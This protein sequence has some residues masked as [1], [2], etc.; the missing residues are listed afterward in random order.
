MRKFTLFTILAFV[1]LATSQE[2][3]FAEGGIAWDPRGVPVCIASGNQQNIRMVPDGSGGAIIVWTDLRNDD[4]DI[5]AQKINQNGDRVWV[6]SD[7]AVCTATLG[8]KNP[9]IVGDGSGGAIIAWE[10]Y[11]GG[12]GNSNIY[13]VR[14]SS[15]GETCSPWPQDGVALKSI[16]TANQITPD[17][18]SV[19]S[20]GAVIVWQER[21][22]D[23]WEI[24]AQRRDMNGM[25]KWTFPVSSSA[26]NV[27]ANPK[28]INDGQG[29][30]I[31]TWEEIRYGINN[32]YAQ[33]LSIYDGIKHFDWDANGNVVTMAIGD[34]KKPGI[35]PDG[36][37]GAIIVWTDWRPPTDGTAP[38]DIYAQRISSGGVCM[39]S[40]D[41]DYNGIPICKMRNEQMN[42]VI[43][44]D[45]VG[46]ATIGAIIAWED[47]R[48]DYY[49]DIYAE[50]VPLN[51]TGWTGD[52]KA[53]A[54]GINIQQIL[55]RMVS[56]NQG[57]G[58]ITWI[59]NDLIS[60]QYKIFASKRNQDGDP[61]WSMYP[62]VLVCQS[63]NI[64]D[65]Q[66]VSDGSLGVII[67]WQSGPSSD[68]NI[69][70]QRVVEDGA[71]LFSASISGRV[72]LPDRETGITGVDVW[73]LKDE[74]LVSSVITGTN[75]DYGLTGLTP[76]T[77]YVVRANWMV[78]DIEFSVS[79]EAFAPSYSI[80]FTLEKDYLL[81]AIAGNVIGVEREAKRISGSGFKNSP[82]PGNGAA[83]VELEQRGKVIVKV[84]LEMDGGYII[85]N[86]L[87]G[88]F[89]AR[90]YN[91]S[92]YSAPRVVNL[93]EGET[94]RV[95]FAFGIIPEESVFNYPNPAKNGSTTIRYYCGYAEPEAEIRIYDIAGE[96]VR[97]V[98]DG[99][100]DKTRASE[101]I[102]SF[103][104]DCKNSS[105]KG[106]A[107]GVYI[108][109]VEVKEKSSGETKK[110][111]KRMAVIR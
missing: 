71:M 22:S 39:W 110:V 92:I 79:K 60:S 51:A 5:Y 82:S 88:R 89:I 81:G 72:T 76:K 36:S 16:T 106:V 69:Y 1:F 45:L 14:I 73:A 33:R 84:P 37:G 70:A 35:V 25:E 30:V 29:Y 93:K 3:A 85:P 98:K 74:K 80:D 44:N 83:F 95:D 57:G 66:I 108:Y 78:N 96:L 102:Y 41:G 49:G 20:D 68:Y 59:E 67:A 18:A 46:G 10:D 23:H 48:D 53:M 54:A 31:I 91:G 56:D 38:P 34:P 105:G 58:I 109:V 24:Y 64:V 27:D 19:G 4:G 52:G 61:V 75:G 111:I 99:E 26:T 55:P 86:L 11:R 32:I 97:K 65:H 42:P 15:T 21:Y 50:K 13:A 101:N 87:P 100:I 104:W 8:Q 107:S 2:I 7:V 90:A 6:D 47:K 94:L 77:I 62:G 28:I 12:N 63:S 17:I 9:V 43:M 103:L 40:V